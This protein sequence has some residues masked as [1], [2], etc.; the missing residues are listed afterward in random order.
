MTLDAARR[1]DDGGEARVEVS[2]I[3]FYAAARCT[4]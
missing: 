2:L 3:K 4:T 1:L